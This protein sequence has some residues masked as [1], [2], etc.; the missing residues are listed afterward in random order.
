VPAAVARAVA[1]GAALKQEP[2]D[3]PWGQTVAY[4][5]DLDGFLVEIC[6]PLG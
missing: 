1:A 5:V 3:M 2:Q 6:T 4:V